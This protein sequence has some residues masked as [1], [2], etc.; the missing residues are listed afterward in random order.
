MNLAKNSLNLAILMLEISSPFLPM[1]RVFF[2]VFEV[3]YDL[4]RYFRKVEK[5]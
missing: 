5:I 1:I 3:L 2:Q 4:I